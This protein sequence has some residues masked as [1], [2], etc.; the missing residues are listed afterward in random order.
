M[1][2]VCPVQFAADYSAA[3]NVFFMPLCVCVCVCVCACVH[4]CVRACVCVCVCVCVSAR[5][6]AIDRRKDRIAI[7]FVPLGM[8]F[9]GFP[10]VRW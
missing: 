4:A 1:N 6:R 9:P 10:F 2:E 5:A 3:R 8:N 7:I